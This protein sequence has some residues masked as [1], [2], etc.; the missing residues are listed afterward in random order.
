MIMVDRSCPLTNTK[1]CVCSYFFQNKRYEITYIQIHLATY[2][3][4]IC[5]L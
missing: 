3:T 1:V 2:I 4:Y 5:L